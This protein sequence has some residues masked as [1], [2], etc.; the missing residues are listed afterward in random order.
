MF[1]Y[2]RYVVL[3]QVFWTSFWVKMHNKRYIPIDYGWAET[4]LFA[5]LIHY[6]RQP[7]YTRSTPFVHLLHSITNSQLSLD[8]FFGPHR[9]VKGETPIPVFARSTPF[10]H[11]LR[12]IAKSWL[13]LD[14]GVSPSIDLYH[15]VTMHI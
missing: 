4:S 5:T 1:I 13:S 14:A 15:I 12:S 8:C 2:I 3:I 11:S 10:A 7:I 9:H 6:T